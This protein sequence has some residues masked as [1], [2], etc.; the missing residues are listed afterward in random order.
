MAFRTTLIGVIVFLVICSSNSASSAATVTAPL[1]TSAALCVS[2]TDEVVV[3]GF[4][5][6]TEYRVGDFATAVV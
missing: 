2:A 1:A 5:K 4:R 3:A 6:I